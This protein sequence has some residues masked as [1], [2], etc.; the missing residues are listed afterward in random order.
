MRDLVRTVHR[1]SNVVSLLLDGSLLAF[2]KDGGDGILCLDAVCLHKVTTLGDVIEVAGPVL[3]GLE[4]LVLFVHGDDVLPGRGELDGVR[5][6][7]GDGGDEVL[8]GGV[9]GVVHEEGED[10]EDEEG[11]HCDTSV[12][13]SAVPKPMRP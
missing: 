12:K 7:V 10:A 1:E 2:T 13:N 11:S 8:E 6:H 5:P 9:V 4:G 3:V